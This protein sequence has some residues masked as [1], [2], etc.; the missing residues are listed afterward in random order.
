M[1]IPTC[2]FVHPN[3]STRHGEPEHAHFP[4]EVIQALQHLHHHFLVKKLLGNVKKQNQTV[5]LMKDMID[6]AIDNASQ[7]QDRR[8]DVLDP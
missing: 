8:A 3:Q 1:C 6:D 7:V 2:V 4:A 5:G